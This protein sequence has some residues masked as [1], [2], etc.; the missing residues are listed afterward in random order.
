MN[1]NDPPKSFIQTQK[2][3]FRIMTGKTPGT[4]FIVFAIIVLFIIEIWL[5]VWRFLGRLCCA[6][7]KKRFIFHHEAKNK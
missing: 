1:D 7:C 2:D 6:V 3:F 4:L 5:F